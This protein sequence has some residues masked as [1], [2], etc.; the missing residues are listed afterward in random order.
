MPDWIA[1][2]EEEHI[3]SLAV[4][5]AERRSDIPG[6][7]GM[8]KALVIPG[9]TIKTEHAKFRLE[10]VADNIHPYAFSI[11]PLPN[12]QILVTEKKYG[13]SIIYPDGS[14]SEPIPGTPETSEKGR[15]RWG[16][17]YGI[18]WLLDVAPHPDYQ[19][20]GW[21]YLHHTDLCSECENRKWAG[22]IPI[23]M[24]RLIR[25]RIS[26]GKWVDSEVIWSVPR[27]HYHPNPDLSAGGRIAFDDSGH[28][29]L[30]IGTKGGGK[31]GIQDLATPYGKIH[32]VNLDGSIPEDNPFL[33]EFDALSSI[34]TYGHRNPQGLEFD[35]ASDRL[36]ASEMGPRGGDEINLLRPGNNYGWPLVSLGVNYD[37][38]PVEG[39]R[40][41]GRKFNL[42]DIQQPVVDLTPSPAVSSFI[43]YSGD[44]FPGW[45]NQFLVGSLKAAELYRMEIRAD[46]H[47]HTEV[48]I[49]DLARI[50][51]V[52]MGTD[53][54]VYLLLEH[55]TGSRIVR[56]LPE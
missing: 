35:P 15:I 9:G 47:I 54:L 1:S 31:K 37:G 36:W 55:E 34:W 38:T 4:L 16:L 43:I 30:S 20:N 13:L 22:F 6:A 51:D 46:K 33:G 23:S 19:D 5:I 42:D 21:I 56:L 49:K 48:L 44:A 25:G 8:D 52:E 24:N 32:R 27:S 26:G 29:Y 10:T 2:L 12:G 28:V 14:R 53:G 45:K 39:W 41:L 40:K 18:G 17:D 7:S 3:R 50:R 11:A